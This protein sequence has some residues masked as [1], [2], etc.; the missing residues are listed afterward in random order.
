MDDTD[1]FGHLA[2]YLDTVLLLEIIQAPTQMIHLD[3]RGVRELL[4]LDDDRCERLS[5]QRTM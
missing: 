3:V 2:F 4:D 1:T 5:V